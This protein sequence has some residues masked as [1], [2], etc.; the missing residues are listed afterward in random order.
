MRRLF[1][2]ALLAALAFGA[3]A[4]EEECVGDA[5]ACPAM[6]GYPE[7]AEQEGCFWQ[8]DQYTQACLGSEN[9]TR[10]A[11]KRLMATSTSTPPS[12]R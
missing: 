2:S 12:I 6:V 11:Q 4:C 3:L 5:K 10:W 1:V 8:Q 7:C 9:D